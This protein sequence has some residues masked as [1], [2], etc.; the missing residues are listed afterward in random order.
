MTDVISVVKK[1]Y[2]KFSGQKLKVLIFKPIYGSFFGAPYMLQDS[3]EA[4]GQLGHTVN[5]VDIEKL[6]VTSSERLK[7][8]IYEINRFSP[9]FILTFNFVGFIPT[10]LK[11]MTRM[12]IP[13]ASWFVDDPFRY[14]GKEIEISPY[15]IVF[16][17]DRAYIKRLKEFGFDKVYYLPGATNPR[18]FRKVGLT[19]EEKERFDCPISFVGT[20]HWTSYRSY[21]EVIKDGNAQRV[22]GE[23]TR[24]LIENPTLNISDVLG[25]VEKLLP[26]R[27][28]LT[29]SRQSLEILLENAAMASYRKDLIEGVSHLEISVY[30]DEGWIDLLDNGVNLFG[31]LNYCDELPKLY[32][33]SK[34]N[35]N[36]TMAQMKTA[37][38]QR[39]FDIS[40]CGGFVLNDY[41]RDISELFRLGE[42][43]VCYRD[44]K[45]LV[46]LV[47][48]FLI[49]PKER[50]EIA[51]RARR[52]VLAEH[53]YRHRM[54]ELVQVMRTIF[55]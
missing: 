38:N 55:G 7:G 25:E 49:N 16:I 47:E 52:R 17:C 18:I 5:P 37:L 26:P 53:T 45:E 35:L 2:Q 54:K 43:V 14:L 41:R 40:A 11:T 31:Q 51:S 27:V 4:L 6:G 50:K 29:G 28:C 9:D 32:N 33:A 20:S 19:R 15:L 36:I 13:H 34:I 44:K 8:L 12:E 30:G 3:I 24:I 42:E 48:F 10:L 46:E 22:L 39:V 23:A 21:C 1:S